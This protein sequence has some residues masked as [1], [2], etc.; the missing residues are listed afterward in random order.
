ME[1][2]NG[3]SWWGRVMR[4]SIAPTAGEVSL[5]VRSE[6]QWL[7][8]QERMDAMKLI[9]TGDPEAMK[10]GRARLR[11]LEGRETPEDIEEFEK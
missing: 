6:D 2:N 8:S 3:K 1:N 4:I 10:I 11:Y 9:Q 5:M 7:A